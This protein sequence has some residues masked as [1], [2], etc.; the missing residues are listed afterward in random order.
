VLLERLPSQQLHLIWPLVKRWEKP[1]DTLAAADELL[2]IARWVDRAGRAERLLQ[3]A[4]QLAHT[5]E[6]LDKD[7]TI[8]SAVAGN[9]A[10]VDLAVLAVSSAVDDDDAEEPVLS[11]R[12]VLRVAARFTGEQTL[13]RKNRM[14]DGRLA[15]ARM[16]GY[17]DDSRDA[18]LGLIELAAALCRPDNRACDVCPL[19]ES[20]ASSPGQRQEILFL[21]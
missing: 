17:G 13:E 3:L 8:H 14:S 5:P 16:I 9:E 7:Q 2:E 12:G 20:C 19:T 15:V 10:A 11:G 1:I 18:H 4:E 21:R 6:A